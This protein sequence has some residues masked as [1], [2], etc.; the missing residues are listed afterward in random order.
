MPRNPRRRAHPRASRS[1]ATT[2]SAPNAYARPTWS[3][4]GTKPSAPSTS[5]RLTRSHSATK[6]LAP[7]TSARLTWPHSARTF[8]AAKQCMEVT[9]NTHMAAAIRSWT[10]SPG[11]RPSTRCWDARG[12]QYHSHPDED[13]VKN[14]APMRAWNPFPKISS[15]TEEGRL[16]KQ[17]GNKT[18][19]SSN[20]R[21]CAHI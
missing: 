7:S 19:H 6:S 18:S 13:A 16:R 20:G 11:R 4:S 1:I 5:V 14:A 12:R 10:R 21:L 9:K 15:R 8:V 17:V 2:P 3:Q